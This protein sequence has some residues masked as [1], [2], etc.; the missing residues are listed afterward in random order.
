MTQDG[1]L[2]SQLLALIKCSFKTKYVATSGGDLYYLS[3]E[4][5]DTTKECH[6]LTIK[7]KRGEGIC[8]HPWMHLCMTLED[9]R[10]KYRYSGEKRGILQAYYFEGDNCNERTRFLYKI[11]ADGVDIIDDIGLIGNGKLQKRL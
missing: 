2:F 3:I 9:I 4:D 1:I 8:G 7:W 5:I 10:P 6:S 11:M